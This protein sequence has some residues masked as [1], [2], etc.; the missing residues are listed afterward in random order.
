MAT[1]IKNLKPYEGQLED[2]VK[3]CALVVSEF[4]VV[5]FKG[6]TLSL[7]GKGS[8]EKILHSAESRAKKIL[9]DHI[10][11]NFCQGHY[12]HKGLKNT[13]EKEQGWM[14]N[15]GTVATSEKEFSV[16][17]KEMVEWL[18]NEKIFTIEK[19]TI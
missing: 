14:R 1:K 11:C 4:W 10:Y 13:F 17:A 12:W 6:K 7:T 16:M 8:N 18:L 5:K 2:L 19:I 15:S 3:F 9:T